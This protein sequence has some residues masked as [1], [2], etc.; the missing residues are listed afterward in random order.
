MRALIREAELK[1]AL[2]CMRVLSYMWVLSYVWALYEG[3]E[4]YE[5]GGPLIGWTCLVCSLSLSLSEG[6]GWT[7][8]AGR[9]DRCVGGPIGA[10]ERAVR[11]RR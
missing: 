5:G 9:S 1:R 10:W 11:C 6:E 2:C 7:R 3:A 8:G 4:L